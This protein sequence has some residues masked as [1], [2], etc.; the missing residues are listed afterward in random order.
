VWAHQPPY[1]GEGAVWSDQPALT[2][3]IFDL[4][5]LLGSTGLI[6]EISIYREMAV[7]RKN[8]N[9]PS[10]VAPANSSDIWS[11]QRLRRRSMP[12]I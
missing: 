10:S 3:L 4:V 12:Q 2:N 7:I 11:S 5:V 8:N 9:T 6:D 1:Q